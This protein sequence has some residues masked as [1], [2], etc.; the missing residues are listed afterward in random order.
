M[1]MKRC[2]KCGE[3]VWSH[4]H[5]CPPLWLVQCPEYDDETWDKVYARDAE[6]AAAKFA[7]E[8]D[9]DSHNMMDGETIIVQ[10]K[11]HE[12]NTHYNTYL[13]ETKEFV[14]SGEPIPTY[15]ASEI[16]DEEE[17]DDIGVTDDQ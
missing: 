1:L 7:E 16:K 13:G 15:Y 3:W 4:Q 5:N 14:C 8:Y 11:P 2:E 6:C 10:V 9:A 12:D 17:T